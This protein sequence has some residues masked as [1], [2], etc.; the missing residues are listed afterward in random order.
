ML[1]QQQSVLGIENA[2]VKLIPLHIHFSSDPTRWQAVVGR[3]D[4]DA[5]VQI[6][7]PLGML[8]NSEKVPGE[9]AARLVFLRQTWRRLVV[10]WCHE[11]EYR[12]SLSPNDLDRLGLPPGS[13][14]F[15]LMA[16]WAW[17]TPDSTF[18]FRSGS[19]IR[20]GR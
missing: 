1:A 11:C 10:S 2:H 5:T 17:P 19:L 13:K 4:L 6:H 7:A 3:V 15:P 16:R 20:Q 14:R 12:H 9:A 18:P 8:G